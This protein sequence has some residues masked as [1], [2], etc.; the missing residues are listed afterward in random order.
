MRLWHLM[1]FLLSAHLLVEQRL[2]LCVRVFHLGQV[3][4]GWGARRR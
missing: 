3:G 1:F 4:S 2:T